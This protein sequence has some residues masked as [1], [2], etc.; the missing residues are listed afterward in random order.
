MIHE[1]SNVVCE[2]LEYQSYNVVFEFL[3]YQIVP[4]VFLSGDLTSHYCYK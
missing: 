1:S 3:E 4:M 2:F